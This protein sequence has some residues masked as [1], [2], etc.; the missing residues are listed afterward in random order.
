MSCPPTGIPYDNGCSNSEPHQTQATPNP[1]SMNQTQTMYWFGVFRLCASSLAPQHERAPEQMLRSPH[2]LV[3][4]TS[5][6][7]LMI[8]TDG[9]H[10][11]INYCHVCQIR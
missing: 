11:T 7:I 1:I 6:G 8:G 9:H 2:R 5:F 10:V 4:T 3:T